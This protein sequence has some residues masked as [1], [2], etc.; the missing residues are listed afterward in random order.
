MDCK[1]FNR[2]LSFSLVSFAIALKG[3]LSFYVHL[4]S[5]DEMREEE[6]IVCVNNLSKIV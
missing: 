1:L 4:K 2:Q 5:D 6:E 3:K